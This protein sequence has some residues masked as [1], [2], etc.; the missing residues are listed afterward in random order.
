MY[1]I[2]SRFIHLKK[3]INVKKNTRIYFL[4]LNQSLIQMYRGIKKKI[5]AIQATTKK[6]IE[7]SS[8]I[9]FANAVTN[10]PNIVKKSGRSFDCHLFIT[11]KIKKNLEC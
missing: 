7:V 3:L 6:G 10:I 9:L 5:R 11:S 8:S 4:V 1:F 2:L